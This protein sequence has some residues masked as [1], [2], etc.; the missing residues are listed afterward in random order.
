MHAK[1]SHISDEFASGFRQVIIIHHEKQLLGQFNLYIQN[2]HVS[3]YFLHPT[4]PFLGFF[5]ESF[6]PT[7]ISLNHPILL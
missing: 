1:L 3:L 7:H 2:F 5:W 4:L 6:I